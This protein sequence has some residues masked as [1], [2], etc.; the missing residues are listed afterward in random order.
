[1]WRR[2]CFHPSNVTNES[3][4]S[5]IE[6]EWRIGEALQIAIVTLNPITMEKR[7]MWEEVWERRRALNTKTWCVVGDCYSIRRFGERRNVEIDVDHVRMD[8]FKLEGG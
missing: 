8:G 4:F 2:N 7:V 1:M 5:I 3:N 6:R